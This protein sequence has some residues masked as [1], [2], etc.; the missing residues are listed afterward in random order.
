MTEIIITD[1]AYSRMKERAG[2]NKS[3]VDKMA[4]RAFEQ[5][6]CHSETKGSLNRY[7]TSKCLAYIEQK[8]IIRIYGEFVY[9]FTMDG[10]KAILITAY[11]IPKRLRNTVMGHRNK[12]NRDR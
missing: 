3:A 9:C 7:I 2:F 11:G 8:Q 1:H 6:I 10:D 5:G 12:K 4:S